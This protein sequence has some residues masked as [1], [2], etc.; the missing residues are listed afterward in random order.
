MEE[1]SIF[2]DLTLLHVV[3]F[4]IA[5]AGLKI[6]SD[7]FERGVFVCFQ[8][9]LDVIESYWPLDLNIVVCV[10]PSRR[11]THELERSDLAAVA[12]MSSDERGMMAVGEGTADAG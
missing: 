4:R 7:F 6:L 11:Q 3:S 12:S 5:K 10:L 1:F 2:P 9:C 8:L